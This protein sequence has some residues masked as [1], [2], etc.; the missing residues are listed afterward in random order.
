MNNP[1]IK[2]ALE[3]KWRLTD[4]QVSAITAH[5]S[6]YC[7][8]FTE[9]PEDISWLGY[10]SFE[11]QQVADNYSNWLDGFLAG[12]RIAKIGRWD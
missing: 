6:N 4:R 8:E 3:R 2:L 5:F 9:T 10:F 7:T 12:A 11:D 1:P